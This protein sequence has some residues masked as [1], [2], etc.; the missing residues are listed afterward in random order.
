MDTTLFAYACIAAT[1]STLGF[2]CLIYILRKVF[3]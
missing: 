2:V 3:A 1:C